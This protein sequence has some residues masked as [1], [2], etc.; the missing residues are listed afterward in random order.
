MAV[1]PDFVKVAKISEIPTGAGKLIE[2]GGKQIALFQVD[3][4]LYAIDNN[5]THVGG[6]L[7]EGE[8]QN[9]IVECPWHGAQFSIET[10]QVQRAPARADIACYPVR[11]QGEDVEIAV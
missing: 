10:G 1:M 8:V 6:P 2:T 7:C 11:Q 3:G 5:C 4:K 9:L